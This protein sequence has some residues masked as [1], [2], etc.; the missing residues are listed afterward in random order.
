MCEQRK[1][2]CG[3]NRRAMLLYVHD[4]PV[5]FHNCF[6]QRIGWFSENVLIFIALRNAGTTQT[7]CLAACLVRVFKGSSVVSP[8]SGLPLLLLCGPGMCRWLTLVL[9]S[10]CWMGLVCV[11]LVSTWSSPG[12]VR[13]VGIWP[14]GDGS[15]PRDDSGCCGGVWWAWSCSSVDQKWR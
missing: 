4:M 3:K 1:E 5:F 6:C 9:H 2:V 10:V 11:I 14:T 13:C 15:D 12:S 8:S 7:P